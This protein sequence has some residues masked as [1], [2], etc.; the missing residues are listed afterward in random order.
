M[1][2]F[3]EIGLKILDR[4]LPDKGAREAAQLELLKLQQQGEFKVMEADLQAQ[5]AQIDV[6]KTEAANPSLFVS[7]WRPAVGWVGVAALVYVYLVQ[8]IASWVAAMNAL[9]PA[10]NVETADLM[11]LLTGILGLGGYRSFEKMKGVAGK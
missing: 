11:I 8:P 5:L 2:P 7:G 1:F 3:I 4:V 10:P 6:N 9:P